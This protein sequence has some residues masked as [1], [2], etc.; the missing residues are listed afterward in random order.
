MI[1][2]GFPNVYPEYGQFFVRLDLI[3]GFLLEAAEPV[4]PGEPG[5]KVRLVLSM[6]SGQYFRTGIV[7]D[8]ETAATLSERTAAYVAS[9][10]QDAVRQRGP[11]GRIVVP[12]VG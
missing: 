5:G 1:F 11:A 8:A 2:G 7:E 10:V 12:G 9:Q 6:A 3:E 4:L